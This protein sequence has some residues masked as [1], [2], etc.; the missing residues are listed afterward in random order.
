MISKLLQLICMY[1][2]NVSFLLL[3]VSD[4]GFE[5]FLVASY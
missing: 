2:I 3:P 1:C 4:A 5:K